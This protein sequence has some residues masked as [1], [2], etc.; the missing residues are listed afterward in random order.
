MRTRW[1]MAASELQSGVPAEP[2]GVYA[3]P[4]VG[5][6]YLGANTNSA[7]LDVAA[8]FDFVIM[9]LG[10]A[11][12]GAGNAALV[13]GLKARNPAVKVFGYIAQGEASMSGNDTRVGA[14][15]TWDNPHIKATAE[16]WWLTKVNGDKVQTFAPGTAAY[17]MNYTAWVSPDANGQRYPQWYGDYITDMSRRGGRVPDGYFIDV[18]MHYGW[19]SADWDVSGSVDTNYTDSATR[20]AMRQGHKAL[21]DRLKHHDPS[22]ILVANSEISGNRNVDEFYDDA[23]N[24]VGQANYFAENALSTFHPSLIVVNGFNGPNAG[25]IL[26]RAVDLVAASSNPLYAVMR[27]EGDGTTDYRAMRFGYAVARALGVTP[28]HTTSSSPSANHPKWFDE[29]ESELGTPIDAVPTAAAVGNI[30]LRR[31]QNGMVAFNVNSITPAGP[32]NYGP[33]SAENYTPPAGLYKHLVGTQDPAVNTGA[34]ITGAMSIPA[35]DGRVLMCVTP[36]VHS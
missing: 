34:T 11:S 13:T 14:T 9:S 25:A 28:V 5:C 35:W 24:I 18:T 26:K 12:S 7:F 4:P 16:G 23:T 36:G 3:R 32:G 29:Y 22:V 10:P 30:W 33:G 17:D 6:I 8:K 31:Y 21:F 1:R 15:Q 20:L 19:V 27:S 2:P